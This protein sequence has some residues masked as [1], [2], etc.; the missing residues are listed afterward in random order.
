MVIALHFHRA[1]HCQHYAGRILPSPK[2][3]TVVSIGFANRSRSVAPCIRCG[4]I[5]GH[6]FSLVATRYCWVGCFRKCSRC[7]S[8]TCMQV[9]GFAGFLP[10]PKRAI[11]K[12]YSHSAI[13]K[14]HENWES[15]SIRCCCED[16]TQW[17]DDLYRQHWNLSIEDNT[18][19]HRRDTQDSVHLLLPR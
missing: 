12:G 16:N 6:I 13:E 11:L 5:V 19:Y 1:F 14:N 17:Y 18:P 3:L 7:W 10:R 2:P 9:I 4:N 15:G 8:T